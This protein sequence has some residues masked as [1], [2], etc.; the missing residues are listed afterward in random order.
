MNYFQILG[1]VFGLM[2]FLKPFYMHILPWDENKF[3]KNTYT[4]ERPKWIVYV[5]ILGLALVALTWYMELTTSIQYS[6]II[7]IM[8]SLTAIKAIVFLFDYK[9]FHNW[10]A[11]M[12]KKDKGKKIVTLDIFVGLFG[13]AMIIF[14]IIFLS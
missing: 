7:T 8:F 12:L 10:V 11:D 2:A 3:I 4:Q 14:S 6:I 13:L 1:I 5:A 9:R